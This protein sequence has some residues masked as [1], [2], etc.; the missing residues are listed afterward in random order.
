[1]LLQFT[2]YAGLAGIAICLGAII[3]IARWKP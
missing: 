3:G 1:M 2:I